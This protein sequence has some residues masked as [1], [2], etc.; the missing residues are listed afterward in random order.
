MTEEKV[1]K[2]EAKDYLKVVIIFVMLRIVMIDM[3]MRFVNIPLI[4]PALAD[5]IRW[6]KHVCGIKGSP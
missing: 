2:K 5:G 6:V 4:D 3:G 1:W